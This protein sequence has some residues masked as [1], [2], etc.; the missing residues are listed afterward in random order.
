[1]MTGLNHFL[2]AGHPS[3]PR[4]RDFAS[5]GQGNRVIACPCVATYEK[6]GKRVDAILRNRG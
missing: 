6:H 1:M 4:D 3:F 5:D 2:V